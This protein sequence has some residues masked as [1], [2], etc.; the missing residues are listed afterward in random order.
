MSLDFRNTTQN[1]SEDDLIR[2]DPRSLDPNDKN[3]LSVEH[4][5]DI[6]PLVLVVL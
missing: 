4:V 5:V 3:S 1:M 6:S 2:G